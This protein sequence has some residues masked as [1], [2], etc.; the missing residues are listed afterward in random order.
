MRQLLC[1]TLDH[2]AIVDVR[3]I[4]ALLSSTLVAHASTAYPAQRGRT[5]GVI[6][7]SIEKFY[8][9]PLLSGPKLEIP[10]DDI[11]G[12]KK[13]SPKGISV[14][15][16]DASQEDGERKEKFVLVYER[17]ELFGRLV[18]MGGKKWMRI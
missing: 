3:G 15:V 13:A 10:L 4:F 11:V 5:S 14:R 8:F 12:I 17:D 18:G 2:K 9:T 6:T 1:E 7:V 16:K